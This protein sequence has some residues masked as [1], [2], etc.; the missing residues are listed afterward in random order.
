MSLLAA[1]CVLVNFA[2]AVMLAFVVP[3]PNKLAI[4]IALFNAA[5]GGFN[6]QTVLRQLRAE[7]LKP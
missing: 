6:L 4:F 2:G 3:H 5:L 7:F 1:F